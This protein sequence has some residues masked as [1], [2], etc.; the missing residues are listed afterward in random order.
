M[1]LGAT[2][3]KVK[4]SRQLTAAIGCPLKQTKPKQKFKRSPN[5]D[6]VMESK[7]HIYCVLLMWQY[8]YRRER[9]RNQD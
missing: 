8:I 6:S 7:P 9:E 2:A 1:H 4:T 3:A 5:P